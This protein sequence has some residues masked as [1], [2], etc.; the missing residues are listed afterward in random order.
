MGLVVEFLFAL[1]AAVIV[2]AKGPWVGPSFRARV[3]VF[4]QRLKEAVLRRRTWYYV[5]G[6]LVFLVLSDM[7]PVRFGET[8]RVW[9]L[10]RPKQE[11]TVLDALKDLDHGNFQDAIGRARGVVTQYKYAAEIEQNDPEV[12]ANPWRSGPVPLRKAWASMKVFS[13]GS[14][15]SV[16]EAWWIIGRGE[17][18]LGNVCEAK[19]AYETAARDYSSA[20]T[21]DPQFW[22]IRGWSPFGWFWSPPEDAAARN[23]DL[24]CAG[25]TN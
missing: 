20:M 18:G 21:W 19:R 23:K 6:I 16:G 25:S 4:L 15:N 17:A 3:V 22:P 24:V 12:K 5:I 1:I 2:E 14:L 13:R 7:T 8:V 10:G 11:Q 9:I